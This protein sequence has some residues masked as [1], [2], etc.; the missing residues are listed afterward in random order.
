MCT[1]QQPLTF[2]QQTVTKQINKIQHVVCNVCNAGKSL[3]KKQWFD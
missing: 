2:Q 1:T 3:M